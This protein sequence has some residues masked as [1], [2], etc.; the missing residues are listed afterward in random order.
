MRRTKGAHEG[1]RNRTDNDFDPAIRL[2]WGDYVRDF[3][4][5]AAAG[6][7]KTLEDVRAWEPPEKKRT[8]RKR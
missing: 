5:D 8:A 6:L 4:R 7:G 2:R 1:F 3:V